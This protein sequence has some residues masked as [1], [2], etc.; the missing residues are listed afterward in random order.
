METFDIESITEDLGPRLFRYF[1]PSFGKE[2]SEDLVQEVFVR[3][4]PL[5]K[6]K[7]DSKK[8]NV[9]MYAYGIADN[10]RKENYRRRAS[11]LSVEQDAESLQI[12]SDVDVHETVT[13][14]ISLKQLRN[15]IAGLSE[16]ERDVILLLIDWNLSLKEISGIVKQPVGTV[17]SHIHRAKIHLKQILNR[18]NGVINE[19]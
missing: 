15:A 5:L 7:Y 9:A 2:L 1:Y 4:I 3:M 12:P 18:E 6:K 17:K 8:G 19:N 11:S 16:N 14:N 13:G 10:V